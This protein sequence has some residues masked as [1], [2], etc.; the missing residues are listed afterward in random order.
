MISLVMAGKTLSSIHLFDNK[1][2]AP[3]GSCCHG[4]TKRNGKV[5]FFVKSSIILYN[6]IFHVKKPKNDL[7]FYVILQKTNSEEVISKKNST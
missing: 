2:H 3:G 4:S 5:W 6:D 1:V 7:N